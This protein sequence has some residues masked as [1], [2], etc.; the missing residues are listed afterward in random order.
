MNIKNPRHSLITV[1]IETRRENLL[2]THYTQLIIEAIECDSGHP[3]PKGMTQNLFQ[4]RY[5]LIGMSGRERKGIEV[6]PSRF[7]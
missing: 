4:E 3:L 1:A 7:H 6:E 2:T 5:I